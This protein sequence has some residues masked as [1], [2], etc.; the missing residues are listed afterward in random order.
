[1]MKKEK[2][3]NKVFKSKNLMFYSKMKKKI[4]Q[5]SAN[6]NKFCKKKLKV[7]Q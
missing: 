5:N 7:K 1:M 6:N 4:N 2:K 3:Q